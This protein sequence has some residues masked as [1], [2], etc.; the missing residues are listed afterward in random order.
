MY[1]YVKLYKIIIDNNDN[2]QSVFKSQDNN[3]VI[4]NIFYAVEIQLYFT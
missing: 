1:L 2:K 4:I 3:K